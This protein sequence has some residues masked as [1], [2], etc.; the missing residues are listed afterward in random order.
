MPTPRFNLETYSPGDSDWDHTDT[1][2]TLDKTAIER[3][4]I[5]DRPSSGA[6]D[7]A[8]YYAVDQRTLWRWDQNASDWQA[9]AGLGTDSD[10][11][12]GTTHFEAIEAGEG[13]ITNETYIR[14]VRD[15][16]SQSQTSATR[17][18]VFDGA[19]TDNRGEF[20]S[21]V[22]N[23]DKSGEYEIDFQAEIGGD[24]TSGDTVILRMR[25][26]EINNTV[27]DRNPEFTVPRNGSPIPV[28]MTVELEANTGYEIQASNVDSDFVI[29]A[30]KTVGVIK[31]SPNQG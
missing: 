26:V 31:W 19:E 1:V 14:A 13:R 10:P 4:P 21:A 30:S 9:A 15:S 17:I 3:G 7:D 8:M 2:E 24:T 18:N 16:D 29:G 27:N 12:P 22:L 28:S 11:I 25:N 20:G 23:V 5:A 6:Y